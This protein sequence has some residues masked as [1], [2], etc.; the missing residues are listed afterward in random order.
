MG[1]ARLAARPGSWAAEQG[2]GV[3]GEVVRARLATGGRRVGDMGGR[4]R[5]TG[6]S[7]ALASYAGRWRLFTKEGV[8]LVGASGR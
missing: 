3:G 5:R 7:R 4:R 2:L 8:V 1:G 6:C